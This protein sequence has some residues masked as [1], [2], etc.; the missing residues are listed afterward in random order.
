[1]LTGLSCF[2]LFSCKSTQ[3]AF[4]IPVPAEASYNNKKISQEYYQIA[5]EYTELQKY[6]RAI[7]YYKLA[8]RD[9][10][11]R[12]PAYFNLGKVYALS[13]DWENAKIV[14]RRLLKRDPDNVSLQVSLAYITAMQGDLNTASGV[15]KNLIEE[16]PDDCFILKN[17]LSVLIANKNFEQAEYYLSVLK[18]KFPQ[19]TD[20]STY[21][22]ELAKELQ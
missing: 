21:E 7:V 12:T 14:Y 16:H 1:M 9:A 19:D 18:T 22:R 15:Y 2:A 13:G 8:M 20:I 3:D 6:D 11:L 5:Q 4:Y 17:Y 10:T